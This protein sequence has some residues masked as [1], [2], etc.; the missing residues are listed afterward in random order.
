MTKYIVRIFT[1]LLMATTCLWMSSQVNN[2]SAATSATHE[3]SVDHTKSLEGKGWDYDNEYGWQCFD[4]VNEQWDYLYGHGLKGDYAKEI[5]TKNN[6]DGEATVYKNSATFE[7]KAGD[8]V[9]FNEEFGNGAGHTAIVTDGNYDG[10]HYKFESLDQNWNGGGAEKT[11]VAHRVVHDYES[12]M[13][14]IRPDYNQ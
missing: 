6:F 7:A 10:N 1:Y 3:E 13:W 11:E 5:P 14:F 8:I 12:E 2:A 9:V 4:L